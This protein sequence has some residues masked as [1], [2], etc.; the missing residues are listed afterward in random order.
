M[1]EL[2]ELFLNSRELGIKAGCY[3]G[4][5]IDLEKKMTTFQVKIYFVF[6]KERRYWGW[7]VSIFLFS[8]N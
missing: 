4:R 2:E 7:K 1:P 3:W 6:P 5:K 8:E